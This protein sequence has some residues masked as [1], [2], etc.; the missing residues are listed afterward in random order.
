M[1]E[2]SEAEL[3]W[4]VFR[5]PVLRVE[6]VLIL[7]TSRRGGDVHH[8]SLRYRE[9]CPGHGVVLGAGPLYG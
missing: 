5:L 7:E 9:V 8:Q 1:A 2:P 6:L 3:V 4:V